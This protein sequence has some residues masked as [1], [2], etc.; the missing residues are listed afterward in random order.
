MSRLRLCSLTARVL[1]DGLETL[2]I[3]TVDRM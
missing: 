3:P 1:T 2:G